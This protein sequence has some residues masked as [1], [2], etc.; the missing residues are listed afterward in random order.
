MAKDF[1]SKDEQLRIVD[2][3]KMAQA[4]TSGEIQLHLEEHCKGTALER[5]VEV[6]E[7]IGMHKTALKNGVLFYLAV[8]DKKFAILGDSGINNVVPAH[9]WDDIKE[10]MHQ[11]FVEGNFCIGVCDGILK[12]GEQLKAHFPYQTGDF[13]ELSDEISFGNN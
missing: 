12:A 5:A 7:K 1:F 2:S 11:Q 3:I 6:F 8:K 9:F 4:N 10:R 13:N